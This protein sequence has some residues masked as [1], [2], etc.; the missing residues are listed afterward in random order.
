MNRNYLELREFFWS[1]RLLQWLPIAGFI[2][3]ARRSWPKALLL[4]GWL[5]AFVIVKGS[6]DQA[7]VESG[8]LLRLFLPGFPP[9]L[10][11]TACIPLLIPTV[12]PRI[13]ERFPVRETR[14][15]GRRELAIAGGLVLGLVPVLLFATLKPLH[16]TQE[17]K[18]FD[19][20]V[21]VPVDKSFTV[22]VGRG[23]GGEL[24]TWRPPSR[25]AARVFYRVYRVRPVVQAP[26]PTLPPG[27]EGIRCLPSS[28]ATGAS[29]CRLEMQFLGT[30]RA[31]SFVDKPPAGPWIYRIGLAA[32]WIN[33]ENAG[34]VMLLSGPGRLGRFH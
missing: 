9:V 33:D 12:G 3:A 31:H 4:G 25:Q 10:I 14:L 29:D 16:G 5:A 27:R 32:N 30:T 23:G 24:V 2:A 21:I 34:D 20:N 19:E 7:S 18:Y 13:W 6:S 17:A 1:V 8:I 26:D 22:K 11:L 15:P 28:L